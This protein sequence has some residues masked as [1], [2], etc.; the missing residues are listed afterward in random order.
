M[1]QLFAAAFVLI[2]CLRHFVFFFQLFEEL[3]EPLLAV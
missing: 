2:S 3:E 1:S